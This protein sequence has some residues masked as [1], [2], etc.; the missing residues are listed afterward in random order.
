[1][2]AARAAWGGRHAVA[3][4]AEMVVPARTAIVINEFQRGV[5]GD[6]SGMSAIADSARP[7]VEALAR[8]L[9]VARPAGV[10]VVHCVIGR[11]ADGRGG[12][13]NTAFAAIARK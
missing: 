1:M 6:L 9:A 12:N 5:V 4:R 11:R 3:I 8:L 2:G 10:A 13:Q 7:A